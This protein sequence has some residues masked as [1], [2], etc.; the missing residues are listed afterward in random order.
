M[1]WESL[2]S[3]LCQGTDGSPA[4][5]LH[6][7]QPRPRKPEANRRA[8]SLRPPGSRRLY[9][10][11]KWAPQPI[12]SASLRSGFPPCRELWA[13]SPPL[14]AFVEGWSWDEVGVGWGCCYGLPKARKPAVRANFM[15]TQSLRCANMYTNG[16]VVC[17]IFQR[18]VFYACR[19][20]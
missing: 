5:F 4:P 13:A 18:Q 15:M 14:C 7:K 10:G 11:E 19:K 20:F 6:E 8:A 3:I 9:G 1:N 2:C 12:F 16:T 17:T